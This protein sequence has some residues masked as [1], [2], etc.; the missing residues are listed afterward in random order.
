[1]IIH[2]IADKSKINHESIGTGKH[3]KIKISKIVAVEKKNIQ[4]I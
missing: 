3:K 1:M 4:D 2:D